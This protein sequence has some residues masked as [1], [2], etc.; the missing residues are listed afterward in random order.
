MPHSVNIPGLTPAHEL[1]VIRTFLDGTPLPS[2]DILD[3]VGMYDQ[4]NLSVFGWTVGRFGN[5]GAES[6]YETI[7]LTAVPEPTT[8]TFLVGMLLGGVALIRRFRS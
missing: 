3:A 8:A 2:L 5:A 6:N 4:T 1:N 7:T